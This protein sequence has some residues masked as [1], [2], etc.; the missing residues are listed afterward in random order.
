[1][2]KRG[3]KKS[4]PEMRKPDSPKHS[5]SQ[6]PNGDKEALIANVAML[7]YGEGMTQGEIAKR[8]KVSRATIVNM[9]R[10]SRERGIVQIR[11]EG[12]ALSGSNLARELREKF[13][14]VDVY[15]ARTDPDPDIPSNLGEPGQAL[16]Q[17]ARVAAM[18]F[19]DILEPNDRVGIAW[20]ETILAVS[21]EMPHSFSENIEVCQL[22]GS[23]NSTRVPASETCTIQ[24][25]NKLGAKCYTLHAPAIVANSELAHVFRT[26]PTIS[27]Q[28]DRLNALDLTMAS[29]GDVSDGTHLVAAGMA[30]KVE[31]DAARNH[32]AAG[33]ICC[34]YIDANG[35]ALHLAPDDL[36][37]AASVNTLRAARKRLL[38][39]CGVDREKA[40]RA[41]I[42]GG[43]VTH[44]CVDDTLGAR[45]L[46]E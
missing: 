4:V 38:I 15:V 34:R 12:K 45:L 29:I 27:T 36:V 42:L 40:T 9:L 28:L 26:E 18:A 43:L 46:A 8:V 31:I 30:T 24:I 16:R 11:I 25:A 14:L 44:L 39:V 2:V 13:G 5:P 1:M 32:G 33:V 23:M 3:L 41:A 17:V 35:Q 6:R 20:G 37:I 22:I 10:E 19:L 7:Y 21:N